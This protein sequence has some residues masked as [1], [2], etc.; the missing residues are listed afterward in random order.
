MYISMEYHQL[1]ED[2]LQMTENLKGHLVGGFRGA[3]SRNGL[4]LVVAEDIHYIKDKGQ[5]PSGWEH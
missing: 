3:Q 5:M 1:F 4:L 2:L